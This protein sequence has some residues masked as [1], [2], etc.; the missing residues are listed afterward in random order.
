MA[1]P[2]A[3][4]DAPDHTCAPHVDRDHLPGLLVADIGEAAARIGGR[5]ARRLEA[6]EHPSHLRDLGVEHRD[7]ARLVAHHER[8]AQKVDGFDAVRR[9]RHRE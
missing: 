1:R 9:V 5:V 2:G 8:R 3:H 4:L 7:G 6:L